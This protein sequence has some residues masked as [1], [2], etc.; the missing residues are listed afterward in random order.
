MENIKAKIQ[1]ILV[2]LS[3]KSVIGWAIEEDDFEH[4]ADEIVKKLIIPVV[5]GSFIV[6]GFE[7]TQQKNLPHDM[8][9]WQAKHL[10]NG[11]IFCGKTKKECISWCENYH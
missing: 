7:I 9:S 11:K 2:N 4:T 3:Q 8:L 5:S 6:N 1:G 10:Y